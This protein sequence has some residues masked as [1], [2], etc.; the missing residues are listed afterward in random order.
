M[1]RGTRVVVAVALAMAVASLALL[2]PGGSAAPPT[3]RLFSSVNVL[4]SSPMHSYDAARMA[5]GGIRTARLS[6]D[7][8]GVEGTPTLYSWRK[9]DRWV[10]NLASQGVTTVPVLF[11]APLWAVAESVP[12]GSSHVPQAP[13]MIPATSPGGNATA[14]PPVKASAEVAHWQ[15]FVGAAVHRYGPNG[16]YWSGAYEDDHAGATPRP[17]RTWQVWNEPNIP[18]AFWPKPN[19]ELYGKLVRV[20]A[21]AIRKADPAA[22]APHPQLL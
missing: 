18:G 20:T 12:G 8:W 10:G 5:R 1:I 7:W 3:S 19:V 13:R 22:S 21:D 9:L 16:S 2:A 15:A 6:F 14:Y 11:G 4:F 17:I